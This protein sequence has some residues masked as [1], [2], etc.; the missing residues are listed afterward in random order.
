MLAAAAQGRS[1]VMKY[2]NKIA[3]PTRDPRTPLGTMGEGSSKNRDDFLGG[4]PSRFQPLGTPGLSD[5]NFVV[6]P[7]RNLTT[8]L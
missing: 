2:I 6:N 3:S 7:I 1:D 8:C 5:L 4:L